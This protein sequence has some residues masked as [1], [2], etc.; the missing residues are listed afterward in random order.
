MPRV[1]QVLCISDSINLDVPTNQQNSSSWTSFGAFKVRWLFSLICPGLTPIQQPFANPSSRTSIVFRSPETTSSRRA[2]SP[3]SA[4]LRQ[5]YLEC[6]HR[7]SGSS[8]SFGHR[9]HISI[10][11][12][13]Y[14]YLNICLIQ[15]VI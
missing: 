6:I 11:K 5:F 14:K 3:A 13:I 2:A 7:L 9:I 8:L 15:H 4:A 1:F 10:D 12:Y